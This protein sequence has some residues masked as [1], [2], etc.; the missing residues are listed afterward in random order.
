[1]TLVELLLVRR[2]DVG[3]RFIAIGNHIAGEPYDWFDLS[4]TLRNMLYGPKL[5]RT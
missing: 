3:D 2:Y 1:M 5:H 4:C